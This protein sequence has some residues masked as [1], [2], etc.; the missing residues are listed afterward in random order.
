MKILLVAILVVFVI[1]IIGLLIQ[2]AD[3][4]ARETRIKKRL[5]EQKKEAEKD[6]IPFKR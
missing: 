3:K 1:W 2:R 4:K 5:E 6:E